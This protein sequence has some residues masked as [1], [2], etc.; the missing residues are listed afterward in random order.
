MRT[1]IALACVGSVVAIATFFVLRQIG[2]DASKVAGGETVKT[3]LSQ[4]M[5]EPR[6]QIIS[7]HH[8]LDPQQE[9]VSFTSQVSKNSH[10]RIERRGVLVRKPGARAVILLCHGFMCT[11]EDVRFL[12]LIFDKYTTFCFDFRAHGE[13]T[14]GQ[15]CTFGS[16]EMFDVIGAVEFIKS[17]PDLKH[18]P[19]IVYGFSMGAVSSIRAQ[20][21]TK[22]FDAAIWDCPFD[23]TD[24]II[25][26]SI[27]RLKLNVAGYEFAMPG[28]NILKRYAYN[29]YVQDILKAALKTVAKMD[30]S[31]INTCMEPIDTVAAA[32]KIS[33]PAFFI[34]CRRDAKAPVEA[35]MD[36]FNAT[37]GVKRFWITNGRHHF[38]SFFYNP[39]RYARSV[40]EFVEDFL[41][42]AYKKQEKSKIWEDGDE[43]AITVPLPAPLAHPLAVTAHNMQTT[44]GQQLSSK[45]EAQ[46][47]VSQQTVAVPPTSLPI[48][49]S[50]QTDT[51]PQPIT[52]VP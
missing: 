26:R 17:Q 25:E 42:G 11:K 2:S 41:S 31:N 14:H 15:T 40:N 39:E 27:E 47:L 48:T 49:V 13:Q 12:R 7:K 10:Q 32:E 30:A 24:K 22:L 35:V 51:T 37:K 18:L 28:R 50:T 23:S 52:S 3:F 21:H 43:T 46:P 20:A 8:P 36:V 34:T 44:E 5:V 29:T 16:L 19:L 9:R 38:D 1:K 6:R 33:I 4:Q 45:L